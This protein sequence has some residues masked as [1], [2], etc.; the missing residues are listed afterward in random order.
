MVALASVIG[1]HQLTNFS[2]LKFMFILAD[3]LEPFRI[4]TEASQKQDFTIHGM[5]AILDQQTAILESLKTGQGSF[6][7]E[8]NNL[9]SPCSIPSSARW[10][11]SM[12]EHV[13]NS[14][15]I[16]G[17]TIV[18]TPTLEE[19][20]EK[21]KLAYIDTVLQ[22]LKSRF[23]DMKRESSK[24]DIFHRLLDLSVD[25]VRNGSVELAALYVRTLLS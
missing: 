3:I 8:F 5:Y 25:E 22:D 10:T 9:L 11:R 17:H 2:L 16:Y 1:L 15:T 21:A 18:K 24:L 23:A 7:K 13:P 20:V 4:I 12:G 19:R 6:E 14:Y